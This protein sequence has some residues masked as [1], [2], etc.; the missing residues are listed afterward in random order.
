MSDNCQ[1]CDERFK[2][3]Q[4]Q[5]Q[6]NGFFDVSFE[7]K[8]KLIHA[9]KFMLASISEVLK[10]MVSDTW[11]NGEPIKIEAYSFK[12]FSEFLK[13]IYS[14]KCSFTDENIFS[15]VDLSEFYQVKSF[16]HRC[17]QFLSKKVYTAENVL[18]F[19]GSLSNYSL[20]LFEKA[21]WK[22]VKEN[23]INLV[24][25][26]G[27]METSKEIVMKIVKCK[28]KIFSEENLFEKIYEWAKNQAQKEQ[29]E[30]KEKIFNMNDAIECE[31]TEILPYIHRFVVKKGFLFSY[32]ELSEIL[33]FVYSPVTVKVI[34]SKGQPIFGMLLNDSAIVANIKSLYN[35]KSMSSRGTPWWPTNV[36]VPSTQ[37][38]LKKR[39][40]VEWYLFY[41]F[42]GDLGMAHRTAIHNIYLL[43]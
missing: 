30:S 16:Q 7:V 4:S 11:N 31:L 14:G 17:D 37:S 35:N 27:F 36:K 25:S 9:H 41:Y 21:V 5:D 29:E 3:F 42:N 33:D 13:F 18:V 22:A 10:R 6:E 19:L 40:D 2:M 39:D 1:H 24:E 34:N 23:G 43:K 20:P 32:D 15:M 38:T 28:N 8:G 26:D 12:D